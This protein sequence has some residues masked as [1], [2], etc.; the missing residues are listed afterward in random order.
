MSDGNSVIGYLQAGLSAST[1]RSRTI[2]NNIANVGTANYRRS[3]V[4]FESRLAEA[5]SCGSR[6]DPR[7]IGF[8][9]TRPGNTP[10]GDNG[11][12][13]DIDSEVVA[14]LRNSSYRKT[15]MRIMAKM[16]RQMEAAMITD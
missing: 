3:D 16:Y 14:L 1:A 2:A 13:V 10:V 7:E 15:Y 6:I 4:T 9:I 11:N 12:D 8:E 5:L